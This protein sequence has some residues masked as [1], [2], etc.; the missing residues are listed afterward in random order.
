MEW[1][2]WYVVEVSHFIG[3]PKHKAIVQCILEDP[4]IVEFVSYGDKER[5]IT[6]KLPFFRVVCEIEEMNKSR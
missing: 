5:I 6:S 3:N 1:N 4:E 2:K